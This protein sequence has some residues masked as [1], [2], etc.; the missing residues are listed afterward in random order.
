MCTFIKYCRISTN[1][2]PSSPVTKKDDVLQKRPWDSI[3]EILVDTEAHEMV[4]TQTEYF[5]D[6]KCM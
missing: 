4:D 2:K 1:I 3:S 6:V 5:S